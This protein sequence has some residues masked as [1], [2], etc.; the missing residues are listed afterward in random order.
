MMGYGAPGADNPDACSADWAYECHMPPVP[1][2]PD[3]AQRTRILG[4]GWDAGCAN[5]P[6][7]W[8]TERSNWVL[9]LT[10]SSNVEV[11]CLELTDHSDCVESH[12]DPGLAC[13]RDT[14]PFGPWAMVG[15]Y[16][17]DSA[18]VTLR[19]LNVHGLAHGGV[20]AGRLRDWTV[21]RVRIAGNGWVGWDGDID[22]DDSDA[23]TMA[24]R[25]WTVEW[26][27][28]GETYPG[29]E[30]TGCWAQTAGGY[31]DGV[32]TGLTGGHWIIE[33]SAFTHNTSDGLDLLYARL[34]TASVE[35]RRTIAAGNAGNQIKT[36]GAV[37]VENSIL[38]S[39]CGF[40]DGQP[41]TYNVDPCRAGGDALVLDLQAGGQA[42]VVN[43]TL[44]GEG[45]CLM[46]A[47]CAL[48]Q[49]CNGSEVIQV[50][51]SIFQGQSNYFDP[52]DVT[53]FAWYDD[54]SVPPMPADPFQTDYAII[55]GTKFGNVDPCAESHVTCGVALG[56][57]D[58]AL[59]TFDAHLVP[60]S[61]AINAGT[62][63][64]A[65]PDD[66][67]GRPRDTQPDLG[68]YEWWQPTH[69]VYLPLVFKNS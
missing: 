25:R 63:D 55:T 40:F 43:S 46:I 32:G 61:P 31:G 3:P 8:G 27:G 11:A 17:Q 56:L 18:N 34:I 68:A 12:A 41:F 65:P 45:T 20:W 1:S 4:A 62:T 58:P 33:D 69:W 9:D 16:A 21:E 26:N 30:P 50:R 44:T 38:V 66:F 22:G 54:E 14:P 51:N 5:P 39:N 28:C 35:V 52:S 67:D 24:F 59:D 57:A 2:G 53:C 36:T 13:Q 42:R 64:G 23:G 37:V 10:G 7:L 19:D 6:Q 47:S 15:L 60:G 49:T 29:G 48:D